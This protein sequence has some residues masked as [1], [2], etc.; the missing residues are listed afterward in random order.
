MNLIG[1]GFERDVDDCA[2]SAAELRFEVICGDIYVLDRC[3]RRDEDDVDAG[4]LVIVDT[5]D[6][7]EVH[8]RGLSVG[9]YRKIVVGVEELRVIE[10]DRGHA[11]HGIEQR[12]KIITAAQRQIGDLT[13]ADDGG[14]IST[15]GLQLRRGVSDGD[16]FRRAAGDEGDVNAGGGV[17]LKRD[18]LAGIFLEVGRGYGDGVDARRQIWDGVVAA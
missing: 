18:V 12:L 11:G 3:G 13:L 1:A 10:D 15:I 6:L 16:L 2:Y 17:G 14:D 8:I 7:V 5:L 4:A 9:V